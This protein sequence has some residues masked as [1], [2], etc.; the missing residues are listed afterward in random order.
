MNDPLDAES[1]LEKEAVADVWKA[2][3]A[4]KTSWSRPWALFVIKEWIRR[5]LWE[6]P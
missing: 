3:L 4:G 2:Y 1:P 6:L 5:N